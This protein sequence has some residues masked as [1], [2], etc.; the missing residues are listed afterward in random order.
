MILRILGL[1]SP[2]ESPAA[3]RSADGSLIACTLGRG[4]PGDGVARVGDVY[5]PVERRRWAAGPEPDF[6]DGRE[7][8]NRVFVAGWCDNGELVRGAFIGPSPVFFALIAPCAQTV[9]V[10]PA[11]LA[12]FGPRGAMV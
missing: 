2:D 4:V 9:A 11:G 6:G 8:I 7:R 3:I 1:D 5:G 10:R 12:A